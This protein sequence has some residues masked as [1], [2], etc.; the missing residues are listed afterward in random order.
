M[1]ELQETGDDADGDSTCSAEEINLLD[2]ASEE[3]SK[4]WLEV[5]V[6]NEDDTEISILD[7]EQ[8]SFLVQRIGK[9]ISLPKPPDNWNQLVK[10]NEGEPQFADVDN[11]G[12]WSQY[13][14]Q[15]KF[16]NKASKGKNKGDY[17]YHSLPTG[18]RP[19]PAD[20][21]GIRQAAG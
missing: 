15:P 5:L 19:V 7:I 3:S 4:E 8:N 10:S 16:H 14:F 13:T 1:E 20:S 9:H 11:P 12:E 17:A 21:N 6:Q 2:E 18:A